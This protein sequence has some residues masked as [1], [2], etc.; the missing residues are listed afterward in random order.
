M[1]TIT[2]CRA[3]PFPYV[4]KKHVLLITQDQE[5]V[6]RFVEIYNTPEVLKYYSTQLVFVPLDEFNHSD[7]KMI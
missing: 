6:K 3:T 2:V 7:N 1:K 4:Y 5:K